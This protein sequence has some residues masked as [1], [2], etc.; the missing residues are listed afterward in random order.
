M[1]VEKAFLCFVLSQDLE[2]QKQR[3]GWQQD[4]PPPTGDIHLISGLLL[5][6]I[7]YHVLEEPQNPTSQSCCG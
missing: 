7:L 3:E 4:S 2:S 6:L 5:Y 1:A